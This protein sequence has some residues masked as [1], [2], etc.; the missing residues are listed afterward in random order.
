MARS[1]DSVE[2]FLPQ[3]PVSEEKNDSDASLY[4]I[5]NEANPSDPIESP[6]PKN[7]M[8]RRLYK[9][10][11][12]DWFLDH[13]T[14]EDVKVVMQTWVPVWS[15][16][17]ICIVPLTLRWTS[18]ACYLFQIVGF[19]MSN[20]G[21][22]VVLNHVVSLA[23]GFYGCLSWVII[24]I[25][26]AISSHMRGW[27]TQ[28]QLSQELIEQGICTAQNVSTCYVQQITKGRYLETRCTVIW[29]FG[30]IFAFT[31]YGWSQQFHPLM[32]MPFVAG[33]LSITILTVNFVTYPTFI[34]QD[35]FSITKPLLLAFCVKLVS[36]TIVYPFTS[37]S[38]YIR[39]VSDIQ[40]TLSTTCEKNAR[41]FKTLKPSVES[42]EN[43]NQLGSEIQNI[44][45]KLGPIDMF[46]ISSRWEVAYGRLDPGDL[47][48][49]RS[50]IKP[51]VTV[52]AGYKYFYELLEERK[53]IARHDIGRIKRRGSLS[54]QSNSSPHS[55]LLEVFRHKYAKVGEYENQAKLD[56][57]KELVSQ[58][59]EEFSISLQDLD[60]ICN[61]LKVYYSGFHEEVPKTLKT[62]SEWLAVANEFRTYSIF[63]RSKHVDAQ[64]EQQ[65]KIV[66]A[67][68][69]LK[70]E[71]DKL[72]DAN[73]SIQEIA[74]KLPGQEQKLCLVSQSAVLMFFCKELGRQV[75]DL[76]NVLIDIDTTAPTPRLMTIFSKARHD[77]N[78]TVNHDY[79][80]NQLQD[81]EIT[82]ERVQHVRD[83]DVLDPE[84][85]YQAIVIWIFS[86]YK[87][88]YQNGHLW[89]W[90][91]LS[92][93]LQF[94]CFPYYF[95]PSTGFYTRN[96]LIWLPV[97]FAVSV[98]DYTAES[99]YSFMAK[100]AYSFVGCLSG[101]IGWYISTGSG[102]GNPY[103]F[104]A[105]TAVI[106]FF[107][108]YYRLWAVHQSK[109][110][111][112]MIS[113]TPVLVLGTSWA[114]SQ[115]QFPSNIGIGLR[116]AITRYVSVVIGLSVA[117]V[118]SC[119]PKPRSSK[120][121]VRTTLSTV[122]EASNE[123]F[124]KVSRFAL[125]RMENP[126]VHIQSRHDK[127]SD[128]LRNLL[129][130]LAQ[131]KAK[132]GYIKFETAFT[133]NWPIETY[134]TLQLLVNDNI[135]LYYLIYQLINQV[136][137][138]EEWVPTILDRAGWTDPALVA[139]MLSLTIMSASALGRKSPMPKITNATLSQKHFE[140]VSSQW[141]EQHATL[142]ERFYNVGDDGSD[143]DDATGEETSGELGIKPKNTINYKRLLSHDGQLDIVCLLL[144]HLVYN[145]V[146]EIVV[147]VKALV[148]EMYDVDE[149]LFC[150]VE[151]GI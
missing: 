20:G 97:T 1:S 113:V 50:K 36:G 102:G 103:G 68:D 38:R 131:I 76:C 15:T 41:L 85:L 139:E 42:F 117:L 4:N 2:S 129:L 3:G 104:A 94:C 52:L 80:T 64:K 16:V 9:F 83:P 125:E 14:L 115:E 84:N 108:S 25:C 120:V 5:F 28:Q 63:N 7:N 106:Y 21:L 65:E 12:P 142:N 72:N 51:I 10:F 96:R 128:Q 138:T 93:L 11:Y 109:I 71:L 127:V 122:L 8:W 59:P 47:A 87:K 69:L 111:G 46:L 48:E 119:L 67:R 140:V 58:R 29:V 88:L 60:V 133:G 74:N 92:I 56:R 126:E 6:E 101:G 79:F 82:E 22:S 86:S 30:G 151:H 33:A 118:A 40:N 75:F 62:V 107:A 77:K 132:M 150:L 148:G 53:N 137:A 35:T 18:S 13:L 43:H 26:S 24:I 123:M 39:A 89:F 45:V 66:V 110:P 61:H 144:M 55:K 95:K 114:D 134:A 149:E 146:D 143:G 37:S 145:K 112:I 135:Q 130:S 57:L 23:C 32:R 147:T 100:L 99:V 19:V 81:V 136:E 31:F 90:V 121:A 105:V 141:G 73:D 78:V 70:R 91:R 27:P 116:P 34:G 54:R 17:F 124:C 98:S 44:R 49:I